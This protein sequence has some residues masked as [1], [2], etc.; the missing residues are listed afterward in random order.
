MLL[1]AVSG[2]T[3]AAGELHA[4]ALLDDV[5]QLVCGEFQLSGAASSAKVNVGAVGESLSADGLIH[6]QSVGSGM[7]PHL[8]EIG[9]KPRFHVGAHG[10]WQGTPTSFAL[11]D[12]R[13]NISSSLEAVCQ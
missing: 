6:L 2:R 5:R 9:A 3:H 4:A 7:D 1:V 12:L 10:I 8:A 11:T 13:F